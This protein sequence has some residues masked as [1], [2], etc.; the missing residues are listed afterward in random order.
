MPLSW[1]SRCRGEGGYAH[2]DL[3]PARRIA[4]AKSNPAGSAALGSINTTRGYAAACTN[5][6]D[7]AKSPHPD[8]LQDLLSKLSHLDEGFLGWSDDDIR[9]IAAP[10]LITVGDCD[11]V[12][13]STPSGSSSCAAGT[14]TGTS[15]GSPPH[16][17]RSSLARRTSSV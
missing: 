2:P 1:R 4:P 9:G 6:A 10:T 5:A 11:M 15:R 14:S 7:C 13:S 12:D 8:R 17:S 3:A 16:S